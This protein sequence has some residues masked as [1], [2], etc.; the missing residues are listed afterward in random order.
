MINKKLSYESF[1]AKDENIL[2]DDNNTFDCG[3]DG[4]DCCGEFMQEWWSGEE[5]KYCTA[6]DCCDP[7]YDP[8]TTCADLY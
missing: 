6:C 8:D 7:N 4:G 1:Y 5:Y 2:D 3:W